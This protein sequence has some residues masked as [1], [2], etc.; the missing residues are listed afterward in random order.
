MD[1]SKFSEET[2]VSGFFTKIVSLMFI[3]SVF[4]SGVDA[5]SLQAGS[6]TGVS[7]EKAGV[8]GEAYL[9][10]SILSS[11]GSVTV[12]GNTIPGARL[13]VKHPSGT[14]YQTIADATGHFKLKGLPLM[15]KGDIIDIISSA[16]DLKISEHL[17]YNR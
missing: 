13:E 16:Q 8:S 10:S 2:T 9:E 5:S 12:F 14:T 4:T 11:S 1:N 15:D 7:Q 3:C 17:Q 6:G